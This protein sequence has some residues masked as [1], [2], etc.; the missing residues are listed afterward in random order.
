MTENFRGFVQAIYGFDAVVQRMTDGDW[1]RQ[2]P[3]DAWV[4]RDV[5]AHVAWTCELIA[6]MAEGE[7]AS[8]PTSAKRAGVF[9]L[10]DDGYEVD[11]TVLALYGEIDGQ[12]RADALA[13][14]NRSR[15]RCLGALDEPGVPARVTRSPWGETDMD[16]WLG[17]A[18]WDPLVHTWDLA[19]AV[20]QPVLV[21]AALCERAL[22]QARR[23]DAEHNLR[24]PGVVGPMQ[25]TTRRDPLSQLLA[26]AGRDPDWSHA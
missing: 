19:R 20:G 18:T 1:D 12:V 21:D 16:R 17:F 11:P 23:F 13:Q 7:P 24:R 14:W 22:E 4:A 8:V 10:S 6:R 26:F 5:V 15:S 2:S 3:C 9:V 25:E